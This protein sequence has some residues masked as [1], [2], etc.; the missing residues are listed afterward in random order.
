MNGRKRSRLYKRHYH[1]LRWVLEMLESKYG[2]VVRVR[3][4][5]FYLWS[6]A[7]LYV[8]SGIPTRV[9]IPGIGYHRNDRR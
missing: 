6:N 3:N 9:L 2:R 1:S 5:W 7:R 4:R 8:R